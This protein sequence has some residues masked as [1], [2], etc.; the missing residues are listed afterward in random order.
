MLKILLSILLLLSLS[1]VEHKFLFKV[2]PDGSFEVSYSAHGDKNDLTDND[3]PLPSGMGW[4]INST[5]RNNDAESHDYTAHR[6]FSRNEAFPSTF[7]QGDSI[8]Q[9][10]LLK[11][12]VN[13]KYNNWFFK[14]TWSFNGRCSGRQVADKYPKISELIQLPDEP[15]SGWLNEALEYLFSE[16]L[17]R[18]DLE[19][20]LKPIIALDLQE[21]FDKELNIVNDSTILTEIDYYKNSGLDIIMQPAPPKL[22]PEMDSIYKLLEDEL[23]ITLDLMDDSFTFQLMLPGKLEYSNSDSLLG[24]TLYWVF[25]LDD[26]MNDDF[27]MSAKSSINYPNRK[28]YGIILLVIF[29]TIIAVLQIR[30]VKA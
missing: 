7:Y 12:P 8:Y 25:G 14:E 26:F 5:L 16:T 23:Q 20:N 2:S 24:D 1:C 6:E 22:Y 4:V 17:D 19:W 21:W 27:I 11:H 15:P 10:S 28:K 13:V 18:T 9:M 3:F 29:L 30:K